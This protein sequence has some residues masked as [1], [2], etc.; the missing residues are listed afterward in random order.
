MAAALL[1]QVT[2]VYLMRHPDLYRKTYTFPRDIAK[3]QLSFA[4]VFTLG[5]WPSVQVKMAG[6]W[7]SSFFWV[8]MDRD[9]VEVHEH[10]KKNEANIP[11]S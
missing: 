5:Y 9:E 7:P 11:P 10:A 6:Y 8:L 2:T 1:P 4:H 3:L